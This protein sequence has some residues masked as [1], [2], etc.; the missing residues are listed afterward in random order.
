M[1][2]QI[3]A[4]NHNNGMFIV[5]VEDGSYTVAELLGGYDIENG[6]RLAGNLRDVGDAKLMNHDSGERMDCY[7]QGYDCTWKHA[8]ELIS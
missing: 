4:I 2:G 5:R 7:L 6:Q 8:C 3:V 1:L